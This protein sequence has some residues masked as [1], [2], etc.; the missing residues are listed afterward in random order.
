[1]L[2]KERDSRKVCSDTAVA[3]QDILKKIRLFA[4]IYQKLIRLLIMKKRVS[5]I[6]FEN[7]QQVIKKFQRK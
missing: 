2:E 5:V 7:M 3:L 1:L 6:K 4:V